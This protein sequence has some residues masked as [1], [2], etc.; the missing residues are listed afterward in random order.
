M[1]CSKINHHNSNCPKVWAVD[2]Q[3]NFSSV[4]LMLR[5]SE[6]KE[7]LNISQL[8]EKKNNQNQTNNKNQKQ[9]NRQTKTTEITVANMS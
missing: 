4:I 3:H 7:E 1:R 6:I 5:S 9:T 8:R 2:L